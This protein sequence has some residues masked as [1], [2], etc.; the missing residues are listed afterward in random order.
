M[1]VTLSELKLA[2]IDLN[3][4][5]YY[6]NMPFVYLYRQMAYFIIVP[7][8]TKLGLLLVLFLFIQCNQ[9]PQ[10]L[11][12]SDVVDEYYGQQIADPYR[13]MEDLE[14]STVIDW[15]KA[16]KKMTEDVLN[17]NP[18]FAHIL[19]SI[20][21]HKQDGTPVISKVNITDQDDYF[22]LKRSPDEKTAKL[23]ARKTFSGEEQL[24]YDPVNYQTAT[25]DTYTINYIQPSWNGKKIVMGLTKNDEEYA[26][27]VVFDV[28]SK[29]IIPGVA[30]NALPNSLGGVEWLPNNNAFLYTWTEIVDTNDSNYGVNRKLRL[31]D[32]SQGTIDKKDLFS[33]KMN[34]GDSPISYIKNKNDD[35]ILVAMSNVSRYRDTYSLKIEDISKKNR[36]WKKLFSKE[37]KIRQ[38]F[39]FGSSLYYRTANEASNFKICKIDLNDPDFSAPTVLVK[40]DKDKVIS[41][42][43]VT[44]EGIYFVKN[45]NGV[46]ATLFF[47]SHQDDKDKEI[48]LPKSSGY[49]SLNSKGIDYSEVWVELEGW[50]SYQERYLYNVSTQKF[51][52]QNMVP[53]INY[54]VLN[55]V[56]VE[57]IEVPSHDGVMVPL[58]IVYKKGTKLNGEN[59]V[60]INA[61]GAYKWSNSPY[62]YPYLLYS[63]QEGGIYATA[64]VRGGGEKGEDWHKGGFKTT[65]PNSWKDLIACT[66]YLIEKQY[67]QA[68]NVALWGASAGGITV[69]RAITDRPD[70][71]KTSLIGVGS[72][73]MLRS[74]F[75]T[76]G[77]SNINEFGTV[78]DSI[79]FKALLEMD[80]YHH[81]KKEEKYPSIYMTAGMNDKRLPVWLSSKFAA[82]MIQEG[83]PDN[84]VLFDTNFEGGHGFEASPD[85]ADLELAKVMTFLLW[86]TGHPE[87]QP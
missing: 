69:A 47:K 87:Y 26:N 71:F 82:R 40:E 65:K 73:N 51:I 53:V 5:D 21:Q 28:E 42:F 23:Y 39:V 46:E 79:E 70:L 35:Y 22:Y 27:L 55:D 41:D 58:S 76:G 4:S 7:M 11:K 50:T 29:E 36:N 49:I 59:R 81:I 32:L 13:W 3:N 17:G 67:T 83:D 61:Y 57:E 19:Q 68:D 34:S 75:G 63:L 2:R 10:P 38:F 8:K 14:D 74:E 80:A 25:S 62:L 54:E 85:K 72:I 43:T 48:E 15:L 9:K 37:D 77:K 20:K 33:G 56:V 6:S 18:G 31:Y 44:K 64:H 66:E 16:Q 45:R 24:L 12:T 78:K 52:P 84:L 86:Q 60:L 30:K 1:I